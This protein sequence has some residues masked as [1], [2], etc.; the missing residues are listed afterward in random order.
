[1]EISL[2]FNHDDAQL[3]EKYAAEQNTSV[4]DCIKRAVMKALAEEKERAE[5]NA[6]I[7]AMEK[8]ESDTAG[9]GPAALDGI[10]PQGAVGVSPDD[11][12]KEAGKEQEG[13]ECV[14]HDAWKKWLMKTFCIAPNSP[15]SEM[16][17]DKAHQAFDAFL[18]LTAARLG[19][20]KSRSR[21]FYLCENIPV[22]SRKQILSTVDPYQLAAML[23]GFSSDTF[24]KAFQSMASAYN[25]K[26][27]EISAGLRDSCIALFPSAGNGAVGVRKAADDAL[28]AFVLITAP[29]IGKTN[30]VK[31]FMQLVQII[32]KSERQKILLAMSPQDFA[33]MLFHFLF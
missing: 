3:I 7:L 31:I 6:A 27:D 24:N 23:S 33:E 28:N 8:K 30:A 2:S 19:F 14:L 29:M 25:G 21:F 22:I 4:P 20:D 32:S 18:E 1:M 11:V 13:Q 26:S 5:R 17:L 16:L 10:Q 9:A 15:S 12:K